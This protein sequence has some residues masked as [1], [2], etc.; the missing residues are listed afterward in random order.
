MVQA[1]MMVSCHG[2]GFTNMR[3]ASPETCVIDMGTLQT[4]QFRWAD[5][6]PHAHASQCRYI[7][8]FHKFQCRE[9]LGRAT[10]FQRRHCSGCLWRRGDSADDKLYRYG[11]GPYARDAKR[12][13]VEPTDARL[14]KAGA[15]ERAIALFEAQA[16]T[17]S[18]DAQLC[19]LMADCHKA[20][21]EP[22]S[23]LVALDRAYKPDRSR[24]ACSQLERNFP[25]RH[26]AFVGNHERVRYVV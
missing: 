14:F 26:A 19:L 1:E 3:F 12:E 8:F 18:G 16:D 2:V 11:S 10:F 21:D 4:G 7:S 22:K 15:P 9:P 20:L 6:W 17:V 23:E 13:N 25:E 24:C 5:F